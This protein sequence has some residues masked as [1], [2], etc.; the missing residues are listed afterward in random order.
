MKNEFLHILLIPNA[1]EE[2]TK[3][4]ISYQAIKRIAIV[5]IATL[6]IIAAFATKVF[7]N[8]QQLKIDLEE[9]KVYIDISEQKNKEVEKLIAVLDD[10][11][12]K[13]NELEGVISSI[14]R[15]KQAT[16]IKEGQ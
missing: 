6:L 13:I 2:P 12:Q 11:E 8:H 5:F 4:K 3:F 9:A 7:Y 10:M 14:E 16:T 15:Y 1:N